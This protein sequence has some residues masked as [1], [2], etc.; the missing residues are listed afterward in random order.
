MIPI[1][2]EQTWLTHLRRDIMPYWLSPGMLGRPPGNFPTFA[3]QNA[4]P[5]PGEPHYMRMQGRQIYA[6]LTAAELLDEPRYLRYAEAGFA[7]LEAH[8]RNPHGGYYARLTPDGAPVDDVI[9]VQDLCYAVFPYLHLYRRTHRLAA[10]DP[11]I[12]VVRLIVEKFR[13]GGRMLDAMDPAYTQ[14]RDFEGESPNIVSV[15]DLMNLL[16]V[17]LAQLG[18]EADAVFPERFDLLE[19]LL[20]L[21]VNEFWADGIFWNNAVNRR[22]CVAKHVDFGHTSKAY[23]IVWDADRILAAQ[24][25]PVRYGELEKYYVPMLKAAGDPAVG[26][27]TDY[28]DSAQTFRP[29][30]LQW[31]RYIVIDQ[32][33]SRYAAEYPEVVPLLENG[34]EHWFSLPFVDTVRP[35][36][37]I[38]EGLREDGSLWGNDDDFF[39]CKANLWK[40][41]YHEVEHVQTMLNYVRRQRKAGPRAAGNV[42]E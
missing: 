31:W 29:G 35:V 28:L 33:A 11:V 8:A 14:P 36:R 18:A 25:R 15:L 39:T 7:W 42:P 20:D 2:D 24:G 27:R 41:A 23:G 19:R 16:A 13:S 21:L 1:Y 26:W 3:D 9:T 38:R 5:V 22:D 10:L 17:P 30:A 12:G 6:Y 32:V 40:N 34:L 37:G 4:V